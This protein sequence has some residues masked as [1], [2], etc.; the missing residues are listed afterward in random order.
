MYTTA[1]ERRR[2]EMSPVVLRRGLSELGD[3]I[4]VLQIGTV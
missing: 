1:E 3:P 2:Q 4:V